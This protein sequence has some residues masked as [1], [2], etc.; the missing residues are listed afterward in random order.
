MALETLKEQTRD[1]ADFRNEALTDFAKPE[2]RRRMQEALDKVRAEL[3]RDCPLVIAGRRVT[4]GERWKS[5]NPSRPGEIVGAFPKAAQEHAGQAIQAAN[6]AFETWKRTPPEQRAGWLFR[7]G[8]IMRRRKFE[9]SAWMVYEVGKTWA[10]ADADTAEAIDF[11]DFY[12]REALR[13]FAPDPGRVTPVPGERNELRYLPLGAGIVIPPWNFPLAITTGMTTAAIVC[14]NTVVLKPSSE[15]P[16]IAWK[17]YEVLAEAGL[18]GGVLNFLP[19][20]GAVIGDYLVDHPRTRFVAFTGSKEVGLRINERAAK[21]QPGQIWI[22]RVIAEMGGKDAIIVDEETNLDKAADAVA[23]SAF[24]F[25]GQKCSACSRAIVAEKVYD[26]FLDKLKARVEKIKVGPAEDPESYM[27]P[28]VSASAMKK[29]LEYIELGR[30]EGRLLA[31]GG[32]VQG[33]DGYFV[34]P[35]VIADVP[36]EARIAQEEIFGPVLAVMKAR[37]FDDA[38]RIANDTEYGL[39]GAVFSENRPKLEKAREQFHVGNLYFNRKCTGALVGGHP[40]GGFNM[41]GTDSKAGGRDYL[42]LFTQAK[43]I[44]EKVS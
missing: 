26:Q 37:D 1:L 25:Q 41:S 2:N 9:L 14:G 42:L 36:P 5:V 34:Q 28:V 43:A 17:M 32:V 6:E 16:V 10:E 19:G 13:L 18:P 30:K 23:A 15:S 38:L 7:A 11:C 33:T 4:E 44:A 21:H 22:K 39:T 3:G 29:I 27:G 24:G 8:E 31:G 35:T 20:S 12:A 40:F